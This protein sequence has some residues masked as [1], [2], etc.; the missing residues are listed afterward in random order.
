MST[1]FDI[2]AVNFLNP[3]LNIFKIS[4]SDITNFPLIDEIRKKKE[5]N[6]IIQEPQ[7]WLR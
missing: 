7:I 1:P 3:Y 4:S 2:D 5:A 6:N